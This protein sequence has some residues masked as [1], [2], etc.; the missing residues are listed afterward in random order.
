[1]AIDL[2]SARQ[3]IISIRQFVVESDDPPEAPPEFGPAEAYGWQA[4]W[5]ACRRAMMFRLIQQTDD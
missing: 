2:R 5:L 4:G 3:T 1:M